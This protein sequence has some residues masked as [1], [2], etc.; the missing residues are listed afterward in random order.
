M[1]QWSLQCMYLFELLFSSGIYMSSSEIARSW[2][3]SIFS[4]L[5]NLHTILH[6]GCITLY[7]H[8]QCK[9]VPFT[10]YRLQ[11][12]WFVDFMVMAILTNVKWNLI[13]LLIYIS[14]IISDVE[15]LFMFL[16]AICMSSLEKCLLDHLPIF[17][18]GFLKN[19]KWHEL[20]MFWRLISCQLLHL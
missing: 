10:P 2:S 9:R 12:L 13:I 11:N 1:L 3:S 19:I 16:L 20:F 18:L 17:W 15:H 6:R 14:L 4:F 8:H 5:S 7:F